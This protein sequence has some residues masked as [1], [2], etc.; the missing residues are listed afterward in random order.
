M[1]KQ[2]HFFFSLYTCVRLRYMQISKNLPQFE[3]ENVLLVVTGKQEAD[4]FRGGN[5]E[6]EK[7]AGFKVEKPF[8]DDR[9]GR[10]IRR[11]HGQVFSSGAV[12]EQQKEKILQDFRREFRKALRD[13][14][15]NQPDT[16]YIFT[17]SYLKNDVLALFPKRLAHLVKKTIS[18]NVYG[19]HP[20]EI[21]ER[22]RVR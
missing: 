6:I 3:G 10:V 15:Q 21:L 8:Y 9:K 17:P 5:G 12:Y 13:V 1:A 16:V 4:F 11:G 2:S 20:F 22:I 14:L 18:A 7:I 19:R